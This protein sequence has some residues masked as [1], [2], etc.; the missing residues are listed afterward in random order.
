SM[1]GGTDNIVTVVSQQDV[2][3]AKQ[4]IA[5]Q[6]SDDL[7]K[8]FEKELSDGGYYVL[9]STLKISEPATTA[10]PVVGQQASTVTVTTQVTYSVLAVQKDDLKKAITDKLNK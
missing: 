10:S 1:S 4:K 3:N 5:G 6:N 8:K 7:T 2:D 9:T